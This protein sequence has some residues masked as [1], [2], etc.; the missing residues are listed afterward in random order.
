[1]A[2]KDKANF[3]MEGWMQDAVKDLAQKT[4]TTETKVIIEILEKKLRAI[5]YKSKLDMILGDK[6][7]KK[8]L[9]NSE[10]VT[11]TSARVAGE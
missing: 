7:E 5:G 3:R 8:D 4:G 11:K 2:A 6:E 1:M 10:N 9:N